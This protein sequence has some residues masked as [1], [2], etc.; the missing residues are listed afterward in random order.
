MGAT[1][2]IGDL[3]QGV[4]VQS[5]IGNMD[6]EI[7]QIH[8]NSKNIE[9]G[10]VFV[11]LAGIHADGHD[12][13]PMAI[14]KGAAV[15]VHEKKLQLEGVINVRVGNTHKALALMADRYFNSPASS[16]L[17]TGITGTNGKTT[18]TYIVKQIL[19]SAGVSCGLIGTINYQIGDTLIEPPWTT[20][21]ALEL[22]S[23]LAR[24]RDKQ[25]QSVV[26]EVSSHAL[27]QDRVYGLQFRAAVFTNLSRDHLDYHPDM[28]DYR[29]SKEKLFGQIDPVKGWGVS[30]LDDPVGEE[31]A[32][33]YSERM[34]TYSSKR[35]RGDIYPDEIELTSTGMKGT[36][37]TPVGKLDITSPLVGEFNLSNVLAAIGTGITLEIKSESIV[38]GIKKA[39]S[40]PGRF[41]KI[42]AGQ[43]FNVIV[44]YAHTPDSVS[45]ALKAARKFTDGKVITLL[46]CGG[47]R[48]QGKRSLMGEIAAEFADTAI[49]TSDNPR[50]ED[51]EK[52]IDEIFDGISSSAQAVRM[53]DR[54]QAI[55][56]ALSLAKSGDTVVLLGKGHEKYQVI[57]TRRIPFDDREIAE[58]WLKKHSSRNGHAAKDDTDKI[59][60]GLSNDLL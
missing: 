27:K 5:L 18:T 26:M 22:H 21:D 43:S 20:P 37:E 3:L 17:I 9:E 12:Y 11:A 54:K 25:L 48:D 38:E 59:N 52:I 6:T 39:S 34:I 10:D 13:I 60:E 40:I 49:I 56:Q 30:N 50:S 51:P 32:K 46:G 7:K 4:D 41:E 47:D 15:V 1:I 33:K 58:K 8:H 19:D 23:L 2:T 28:E 35:L 29:R 36:F 16:T 24:M 55:E 57:G 53:V 31:I 45:R 42:S 14:E 44:D